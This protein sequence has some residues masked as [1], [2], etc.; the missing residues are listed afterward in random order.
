MEGHTTQP[1]LAMLTLVGP[2]SRILGDVCYA[3][4]TIHPGMFCFAPTHL[5]LGMS[6]NVFTNCRLGKINSV[7]IVE[8]SG[9]YSG[10]LVAAH[11][12]A[13]L[14]GVVHDG[15]NAPVYL[16]GPGASFCSWYDPEL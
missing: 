7:A 10:V 12:I 8:D 6:L 13:H 1:L 11:E 2:A 14:L 4:L 3:Q 15:D 5:K 16:S 9:G